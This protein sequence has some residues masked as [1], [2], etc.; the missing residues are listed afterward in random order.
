MDNLEIV[1]VLRL[2]VGSKRITH[3][4]EYED[5]TFGDYCKKLGNTKDKCYK[6]YRYPNKPSP[7]TNDQPP[8][9]SNY[10][11]YKGKGMLL[12]CREDYP[13]LV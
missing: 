2:P 12:I 5:K 6:I 1:V 8:R 3:T 7:G 10:K 11:G 13:S 4:V 9:N